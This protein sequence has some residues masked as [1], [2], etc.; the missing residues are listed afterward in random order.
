MLWTSP[1]ADRIMEKLKNWDAN[2]LTNSS[3]TS[4][5]HVWERL[6]QKSLLTF[7]ELN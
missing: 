7:T 5:Y 3:E 2:M 4:F 6:F 1:K